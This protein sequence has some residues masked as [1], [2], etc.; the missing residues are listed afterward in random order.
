MFKNTQY[1][2]YILIKIPILNAYKNKSTFLS[3]SENDF[4]KTASCIATHQMLVPGDKEMESNKRFFV[5]EEA[6][7]LDSFI[8][9]KE[10]VE[11]F[12]RD[13]YEKYLLDFINKQFVFDEEDQM[14]IY[15]TIEND[16]KEPENTKV[17]LL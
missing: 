6:L 2:H 7:N 17:R 8:A 5:E 11:Y 1:Y 14:D 9:R 3:N 4:E 16:T 15:T 10:A 13:K 12:N